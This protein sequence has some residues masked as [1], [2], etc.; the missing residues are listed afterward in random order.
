MDMLIWI[1][2]A[3]SAIGLCG[4]LWSLVTVVRAKRAGLSDDAMRARLAKVLP[5]NLGA[6]LLSVLGLM[7]V[8]VGVILS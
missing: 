5:V 4:I 8:V 3:I 2:A 1:G 6:M 7:A